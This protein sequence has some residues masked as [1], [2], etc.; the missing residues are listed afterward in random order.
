MDFAS[1]AKNITPRTMDP[2]LYVAATPIGNA[3]DLTL[4]VLEALLSC[5]QILC[6]DTRVTA[7]LLALYGIKK[8][9]KPYHDRNGARVRPQV[10]NDIARGKALVLVSDAGM[11][12]IS[13][14]GFPLIRAVRDEGFPV[15]VLPGASASLA[16]LSLSGMAPDRFYFGGFLP[17]KTVARK[18]ELRAL[19]HLDA[20]L[21]FYESPRRLGPVLCDMEEVLGTREIAVCRELTKKFEEIVRGPLRDLASHYKTAPAPKGEV[22]LVLGPPEAV[23]AWD[24]AEL[25][26][27]L[28][29]RM[30]TLRLKE[31]VA[32]ITEITGRPRREIYDLALT[33]KALQSK[34]QEP[35]E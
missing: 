25:E 29:E 13:D 12:L 32:E 34:D 31:A 6:E 19:A 21:I 4:R 9:L 5:D 14:P 7:K 8:P 10:L 11:P 20:S 2:G 16:A 28:S 3:A 27:R 35:E 26:R 23:E 24:E 22:V 30:E 1:V 33:V 17:Q 18:S 15:E